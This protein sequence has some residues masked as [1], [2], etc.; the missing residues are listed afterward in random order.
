MNVTRGY[1]DT[2]VT[3]VDVWYLEAKLTPR[4]GVRSS[5]VRDAG[6]TGGGIHQEL[7]GTW[8]IRSIKKKG[9]RDGRRVKWPSFMSDST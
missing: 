6:M 2:N 7:G 8:H 9:G 3:A 5:R 4:A 1:V